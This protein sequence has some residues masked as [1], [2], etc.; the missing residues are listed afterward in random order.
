MLFLPFYPPA[1]Q[2]DY[3]I[4]KPNSLFSTFRLTLFFTRRQ[5]PA[6]QS[7]KVS[8]FSSVCLTLAHGPANWFPQSTGQQGRQ[9]SQEK[10][11]VLPA[12]LWIPEC[13]RKPQSFRVNATEHG[14]DCS[15]W[16]WVRA[17]ML[18]PACGC[19][20]RGAQMR[21]PSVFPCCHL[22]LLSQRPLHQSDSYFRRRQ[23]SHAET[24]Q[25]SSVLLFFI[26]NSQP[27]SLSCSLHGQ[28]GFGICSHQIHLEDSSS[29]RK[30]VNR[31]LRTA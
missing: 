22:S 23:V 1:F 28:N 20:L 8:L 19:L 25:E 26:P 4:T 3:T 13:G 31:L 11:S 29:Q 10:K 16:H 24:L 21:E 7:N 14:A 2:E 15:L 18:A 5:R 27:A 9:R 6:P 30:C 12:F 17:G